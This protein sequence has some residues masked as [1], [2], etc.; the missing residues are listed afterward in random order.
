M[1]RGRERKSR[2]KNNN[3]KNKTNK[4]LYIEIVYNKRK[5]PQ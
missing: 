1:P 3:D 4:K 5:N 2:G